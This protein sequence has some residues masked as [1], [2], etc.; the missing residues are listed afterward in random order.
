ML[1]I[2]T[3]LCCFLDTFVHPAIIVL[4]RLCSRNNAEQTQ[5]IKNAHVEAI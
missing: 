2:E 5:I 1:D 4:A 3:L